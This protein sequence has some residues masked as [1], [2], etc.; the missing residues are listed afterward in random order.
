MQRFSVQVEYKNNTFESDTVNSVWESSLLHN[1][2]KENE[3]ALK[4][5]LFKI[6]VKQDNRYQSKHCSP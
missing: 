5:L 6:S 2:I 3:N 4:I 1:E